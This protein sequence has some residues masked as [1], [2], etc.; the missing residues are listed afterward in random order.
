M[1]RREF[2]QTASFAA[3]GLLSLPTFLAAG[4][5]KASALGLQLKTLRETKPA[6]PKVVLQNVASFVNKELEN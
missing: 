2:V 1:K 6:D 5:V 4:K 3:A